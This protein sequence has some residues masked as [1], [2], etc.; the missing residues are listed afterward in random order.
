MVCLALAF[1]ILPAAAPAG[2]WPSWRGPHGDGVSDE[3]GLPL[4]WGPSENIAWKTAIPGKGHSSPIV[5]GDR[6]FVTSCREKEQQR[7]LLCL[8]R[9]DGRILWERIV[10]TAPLEKLHALNSRASST[11]ATDGHHVWVTFLAGRD[12]Q[13][14][15]YSFDGRLVWRKSPG[16]FFSPHGFCS[17]P[18][19]YRDLLLVNGDQDGDGYLVALDKATGVERWRIDRPNHTRSYCPPLVFDVAGRKQVVLSG[20]KCVAGYDADSGKQ[21]WLLDGPTEQ[22]VASLILHDGSLYLTAGFPTYHL[23]AIRPDGNGNITQPHV[24]WHDATNARGAAYVP[25]MIAH[26]PHVFVVSDG[27]WASCLDA[28]TGKRLWQERLGA[29]HSASPV[30]AGGYLYFLDDKGQTWVLKPGDKREVVSCNKLDEECRASPAIAHGQFFIRT[31]EHL[32]CI[33][34]PDKRA[35]RASAP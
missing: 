11:P 35:G 32:Y 22:F 6:V 17:S 7:I 13:V 4:R 30:S 1:L 33:G 3:T 9:R 8:D 10:L 24:Q 12:V 25:S 16:T 21:L 31:L 26:G 34:T 5:W 28:R 19:L 29:H 15:C 14:A 27:G 23:M 2:E 18:T 20:S